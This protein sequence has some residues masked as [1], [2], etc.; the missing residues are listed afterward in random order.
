[1]IDKPMHADKITLIE[2]P[3]RNKHS[4]LDDQRIYGPMSKYKKYS[5]SRGSWM[6]LDNRVLCILEDKEGNFGTSLTSGGTSVIGI[7]KDQLSG[8]LLNSE[9]ININRTYDLMYSSTSP[10]GHGRII[11]SGIAAVDIALWNLISK[12]KKERIYNMLGGIINENLKIYGTISTTTRIKNP[13]YGLYKVAANFGPEDGRSG[14]NSLV[15]IIRRLK[16]DLG[17]DKEI[18]IDC[19][20]SWDP[21]FT[22][23]VCNSLRDIGIAWI[24]DPVEPTD[25]DGYKIIRRAIPW[26]KIAAGNFIYDPVEANRFLSTRTINI[27]QPDLSWCGGISAAMRMAYN[28]QTYRVSFSPHNAA[29]QPW[30][31][32]VMSAIPNSGLAEL[33]VTNSISADIPFYLY[34]KPSGTQVSPD[35]LGDLS[36]QTIEELKNDKKCMEIQ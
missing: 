17:T 6:N 24:E 36:M 20:S 16:K 33:V 19:F 7:I 4:W 1:M 23:E 28:A 27:I 11:M 34:G 9:S 5:A 31:L 2:L 13:I 10:Y 14:I 8:F 30:A 35:N 25:L 12:I 29:S 3:K 21:E 18:A 22:I 32:Q 26:Q 15:K